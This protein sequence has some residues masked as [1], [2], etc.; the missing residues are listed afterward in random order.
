[1][2]AKDKRCYSSSDLAK[3]AKSD[4]LL[5]GTVTE[6]GKEAT[7]EEGAAPLK[8]QN[9]SYVSPLLQLRQKLSLFATVCPIRYII[10]PKNLFSFV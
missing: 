5:L 10:G 7:L 2:L 6:K 9:L 1:M 8:E 4:A 3:I